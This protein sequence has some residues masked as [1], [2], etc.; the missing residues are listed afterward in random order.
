MLIN[1]I[2]VASIRNLGKC[3]CPRC[4]ILL[5]DVH[6]LGTDEDTRNRQ[7]LVRRDGPDR[8]E[9]V[10]AARELIYE[11]NYAVT[12]P[13]VEAL[14]RGDSLVPTSVSDLPGIRFRNNTL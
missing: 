1:R 14:L 12:T 13:Q 8:V 5:S 6:E 3:P 11:A 4:K 7:L 9:R 10:Q 2:L